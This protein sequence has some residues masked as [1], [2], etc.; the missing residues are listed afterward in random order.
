M[1]WWERNRPWRLRGVSNAKHDQKYEK[2]GIIISWANVI[3]INRR[4]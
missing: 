3:P 4:N 1:W 2:L